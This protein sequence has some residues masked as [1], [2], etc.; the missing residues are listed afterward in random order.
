MAAIVRSYI[1]YKPYVIFGLSA[2]VFAVLGLLPFARYVVL[3]GLGE[4]GH[5]HLQS[6]IVGAVLLIVSFL[7]VMLGVLADL[8]RTNRI[9]LENSLEHARRARFD[10]PDAG[11][12]PWPKAVPS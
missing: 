12:Q 11:D 1:M 10:R 3:L 9:L 8:I 2:L 6:L 7:S 4:P 5:G